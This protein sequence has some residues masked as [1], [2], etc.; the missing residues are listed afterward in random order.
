VLES[1]HPLPYVMFNNWNGL[2]LKDTII[3]TIEMIVKM[4]HIAIVLCPI[5]QIANAIRIKTQNMIER[6]A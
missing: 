6:K 1:A 3:N 4:A 2:P 5:D